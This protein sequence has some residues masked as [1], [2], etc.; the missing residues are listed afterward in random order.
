[1]RQMVLRS[2]WKVAAVAIVTAGAFCGQAQAVNDVLAKWTFDGAP[3]TGASTTFGPIAATTGFTSNGATG[4]HAL[5]AT[6]WSSPAGNGSTQSFSANVWSAGDYWEFMADDLGSNFTNYGLQF[7]QVSSTTGPRD[8]KVQYSTN[9]TTFTDLPGGAYKVQ[10]NS[11]PAWSGNGAVA[12]LGLDTFNFD[13]RSI[14]SVIG[15]GSIAGNPSAKIRLTALTPIVAAQQGSSAA[16]G[17]TNRIDN[18]S[19]FYNY[20]PAQAPVVNPIAP[21]VLPVTGDVV[22]GIGSGRQTTTLELV[23]GTATL[24]GGSKPAP[25]SPWTAQNFIK[26][27]KFDNLGGASHNVHGNLLGVD[28]GTAATGGGNIYSLATQGSNPSPAPQLLANTGSTSGSAAASAIGGLSVAPN[29]SKV[30][31]TGFNTGKVIVYDYTPG[32]GLGTGSPALSGLRQSAAILGTGSNYNS[33]QQQGTTWKDD[34]TVLTLSGEGNLYEVDAS[35]PAMTNTLK[36]TVTVTAHANKSTALAYNPAVSPYVYAMYS[37]FSSTTQVPASTTTNT[38]FIFDPAAAYAEVTPSGGID[39]STSAFAVRDIALDATGNLFMS[40][41]GSTGGGQGR[42]EYIPGITT[43]LGS[44][45]ANSSVD[46][47]LDEVFG[48][49]QS[50]LDIG[51]APPAGLAGDFNSN[52]TVD[53]GDYVVWRKNTGNAALPNDGGAGNQAARYT[54][55]RSN[56]GKPPG[57]GSGEGLE[58]AGVPE[59]ASA[60]LLVIGLAAFCSRRNRG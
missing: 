54:L 1:M 13:L 51:F 38:L 43:S 16:A 56:F 22:F 39:F 52:G 45:G 28:T 49:V 36:K 11:T 15:A 18:V 10:P 35:T 47:Y 14:S 31:V 37:S 9:G 27:V 26:F 6:T 30:A 8:F 7:D 48:G 42:I 60:V 41:A 23:R 3:I 17:G 33:G 40:T 12:P 5:P 55:W 4:V 25:Y 29:N 58:G 2:T 19:I 44:T 24:N 20:D 34:N 46:W 59:P 50:G 32:N 57:A 53:A 21:P